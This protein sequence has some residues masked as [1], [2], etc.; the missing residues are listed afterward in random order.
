MQANFATFSFIVDGIDYATAIEPRLISLS[1]KEQLEGGAD[2]LEIT[3]SNHDGAL[4]AIK[5]GVYAALHLG[6]KAGPDV[7]PGLADKGRFLVDQ[8]VKEGPPDTLKITAR[9]ADLT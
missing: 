1:L 6:W 3:L 8:I 7:K 4:P 5:R 2:E 9:S